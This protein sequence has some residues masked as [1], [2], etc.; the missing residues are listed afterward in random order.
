MIAKIELLSLNQ[1]YKVTFLLTGKKNHGT[2]NKWISTPSKKGAIF[3]GVTR[4]RLGIGEES[5]NM[6]PSTPPVEPKDGY[7]IS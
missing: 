2:L 1:L 5:R 6:S 7:R 4:L 3:S